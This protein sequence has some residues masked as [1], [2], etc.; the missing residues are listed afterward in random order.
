MDNNSKKYKIALLC[1]A[2]CEGDDQLE[3]PLGS[4]FKKDIVLSNEAKFFFGKL[5]SN[6]DFSMK[7][8][9][10]ID[11]RCSS[12]LYQTFKENSE[13]LE[14]LES[15]NQEI[16]KAYNSYRNES[17][18]QSDNKNIVSDFKNL[19]KNFVLDEKTDSVSESEKEIFFKNISLC[20]FADELFNYLRFPKIYQTETTKVLKLYYSAFC[21]II[22]SL[23][24]ISKS[25][26]IEEYFKNDKDKKFSD[27]IVQNRRKIQSIIEDCESSI[28]EKR[29]DDNNLYYSIIKKKLSPNETCIITTNYTKFAQMITGF[30]VAYL[31]GRLDIFEDLFTKKVSKIENFTNYESVIFPFIFI[32]SG[33]KPIVCKWQVKQYEMAIKAFEEAEALIILGYSINSDDEHI[34]N[35]IRDRLENKKKVYLFKYENYEDKDKRRK[36]KETTTEDFENSPYLK[37]IFFS[38]TNKHLNSFE[39]ELNNILTSL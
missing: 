35:F 16:I 14:K 37:I 22:K 2:G 15:K 27:D 12:I 32:P 24:K 3:L 26:T 28:I 5:N 23:L 25:K 34:K 8:G 31:H 13:L 33:V 19:Y 10:I 29:K 18:K 7:N 20:S 17:L 38:D 36:F 21:S 39:D 11:A 9:A 6:K 30:D 1:G 4:F